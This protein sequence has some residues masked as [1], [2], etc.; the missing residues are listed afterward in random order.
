MRFLTIENLGLI[1]NF[2]G[3]IFV[4]LSIGKQKQGGGYYTNING[5]VIHSA[6]VNHPYKFKLGLI[7]I[8]FGFLF[9]FIGLNK[10]I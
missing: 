7:M 10:I 8:T 3:T 9:Q 2:T 6:V 1:L 4:A 5:K